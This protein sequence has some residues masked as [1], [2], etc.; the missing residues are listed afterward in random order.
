MIMDRTIGLAAAVPVWLLTGL[1]LAAGPRQGS[2]ASDQSQPSIGI[3]HVVLAVNNLEDMAT[4]YRQFGFALKPGRFHENGIRNEHVKFTDGTE[5]ELLT[6]SEPKD[7]MTSRY[8]RHL[9]AG[10]G[11]AFLSL[12]PRPRMPAPAQVPPYIFFGAG[13]QSPTDRPEHFAHRNSATSLIGVW[14]AGPD[15]ELKELLA[16][17]GA[18]TRPHRLAA[19]DADADVATL[20]DGVLYLLPARFRIKPDRP[21]VGVTFSVRSLADTASI[22]RA[23]GIDGRP[24]PGSLL[25]PPSLAG[26]LWVE[27]SDRARPK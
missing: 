14:L 9:A 4:R 25:I 12:R 10:D 24:S 26:D 27:F 2:S 16:H 17:Y 5:L 1:A 15:P 22:L 21:V 23:A 13:N 11:P 19:L 18:R 3:D 8:R 7:A 6:V 20:T